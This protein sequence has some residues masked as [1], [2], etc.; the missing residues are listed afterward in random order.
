MQLDKICNDQTLFL[1]QNTIN[2]LFSEDEINRIFEICLSFFSELEGYDLILETE[3]ERSFE[4]TTQGY[5]YVQRNFKI[6][7]FEFANNVISKIDFDYYKTILPTLHTDNSFDPNITK[8]FI[9]NKSYMQTF[10]EPYKLST[11]QKQSII[12][13]IKNAEGEE[14]SFF[15]DIG[16]LKRLMTF[17]IAAKFDE[18]NKKLDNDFDLDFFIKSIKTAKYCVNNFP[19]EYQLWDAAI[20]NKQDL[21]PY[22]NKQQISPDYSKSHFINVLFT[23]YHMAC[24]DDGEKLIFEHELKEICKSPVCTARFIKFLSEHEYSPDF[25]RIYQKY[26]DKTNT[27]PFFK[28][29]IFTPAPLVF[30]KDDD[31]SHNRK[32]YVAI[33]QSK[34]K[35][36]SQKDIY[37]TLVKLHSILRTEEYISYDTPLALFVYR[38]SGLLTPVHPKSSMVWTGTL[39]T[40]AILINLLYNDGN[41]KLPYSIVARFWG[42]ENKNLSAIYASRKIDDE[43]K[44]KSILEDCGFK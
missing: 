16:F 32:W 39:K 4:I 12:N 6:D 13:Y 17:I 23:F 9:E 38:F 41:S 7:P 37:E 29:D 15:E 14:P 36:S 5:I 24:T 44:I 18:M 27:H 34:Y 40:L 25:C 33:A 28:T 2:I 19:N 21:I 22:F 30:K 42:I 43:N 26:L 35:K 11:E 1:N 20:I 10:F 3:Q 31:N 8:A